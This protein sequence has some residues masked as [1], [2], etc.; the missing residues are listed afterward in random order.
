[1]SEKDT[2]NDKSSGDKVTT[3]ILSKLPKEVLVA[4]VL[5]LIGAIGGERLATS[6][7][8]VVTK[9]STELQKS[10]ES[11]VQALQ[12]AVDSAS[13]AREQ[14]QN[15]ITMNILGLNK[16]RTDMDSSNARHAK[17]FGAIEERIKKIEASQ[18]KID[19]KVDLIIKL[20]DE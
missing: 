18:S 16:L 6:V 1:M 10:T 7:E 3:S 12:V 13:E 14:N 5:I 17:G 2:S 15:L 20:L 9:E 8:T 19:D 4:A 11:V